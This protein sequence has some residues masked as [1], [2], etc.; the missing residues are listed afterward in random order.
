MQSSHKA[1]DALKLNRFITSDFM[2]KKYYDSPALSVVQ[3][4]E[5][6]SILAASS[7]KSNID[8]W[9]IDEDE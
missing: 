3:I 9:T 1:Q 7:A 8:D 6:C 4:K 5:N 2:E